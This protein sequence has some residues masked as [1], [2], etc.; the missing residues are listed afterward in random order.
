MFCQSDIFDSSFMPMLIK[1][2]LAALAGGI[3]GWEREL[4]GR[5]AGLRTHLLVSVGSCLMMLISEGVFLKYGQLLAD[6]SVRIDPG[7]IAAQVITGI[8]FLGAGVIIKEGMSVRGLTTAASLWV[9]SGIGMAFGLGMFAVGLL[10]TGVVSTVLFFLKKVDYLFKKDRFLRLTVVAE[11]S[12]DLYPLMMQVFTAANLTVT[13]VEHELN[14]ADNC[15]TY[16][17]V[18]TRQRKRIG[19][20]MVAAIADIPGVKKIRYK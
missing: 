1:I 15:S 6:S 11:N 17:F 18:V 2:A 13:N 3:V 4:H 7:R 16:D 5:P 19:E 20:E 10:C 12:A 8:G 9:M 14:F